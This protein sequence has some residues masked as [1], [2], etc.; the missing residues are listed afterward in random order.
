MIVKFH[1]TQVQ[2]IVDVVARLEANY[3]D[4]PDGPAPPKEDLEVLATEMSHLL[5]R[6]LSNTS[7]LDRFAIGKRASEI[8]SSRIEHPDLYI[9]AS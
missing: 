7:Q 1:D 8:R 3:G 2:E 9:H 5:Q 6:V 4:G